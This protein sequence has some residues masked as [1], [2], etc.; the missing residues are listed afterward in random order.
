MAAPAALTAYELDSRVQRLM[1]TLG[2][3][4]THL[5]RDVLRRAGEREGLVEALL[6]RNLQ[7]GRSWSATGCWRKWRRRRWPCVGASGTP[8]AGST[9][10]WA[11]APGAQPRPRLAGPGGA[12]AGA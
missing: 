5:D 10:R 9:W 6:D 2:E 1:T 11:T 4:L 7:W 12:A 8:G 3:R